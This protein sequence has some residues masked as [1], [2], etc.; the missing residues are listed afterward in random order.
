MCISVPGLCLG[1]VEAQR[2]GAEEK[3]RSL[4]EMIVKGPGEAEDGGNE[5]GEGEALEVSSG[6]YQLVKA[7]YVVGRNNKDRKVERKGKITPT[8]VETPEVV[9]A[10]WQEGIVIRGECY[11]TAKDDGEEVWPFKDQGLSNLEI[12]TGNNQNIWFFLLN[13]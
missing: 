10:K 7:E 6:Q 8:I 12:L 5:W 4:R 9:G 11:C 13:G 1:C 3:I 2:R